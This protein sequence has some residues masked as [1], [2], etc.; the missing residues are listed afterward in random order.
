MDFFQDTG[1]AGLAV[2][3]EGAGM[4]KKKIGRSVLFCDSAIAPTATGLTPAA[5]RSCAQAARV[6]YYRVNGQRISANGVSL[7]TG[8]VIMHKIDG[9]GSA[10]DGKIIMAKHR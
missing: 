3:Y 9:N 2:Y 1:L 10:H 4:L 7:R 8:L 5:V 6:E